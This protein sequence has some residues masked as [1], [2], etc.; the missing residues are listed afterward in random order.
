M[1]IKIYR[2]FDGKAVEIANGLVDLAYPPKVTQYRTVSGK[3]ERISEQIREYI[4]LVLKND[5]LPG[6]L[7]LEGIRKHYGPPVKKPLAQIGGMDYAWT[8]EKTPIEAP[9]EE[10]E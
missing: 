2:Y 4:E 3:G 1:L 6:H 9:L 10:I 5:L 7:G 8:I